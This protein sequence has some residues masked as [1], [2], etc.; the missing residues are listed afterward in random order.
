MRNIIFYRLK[1]G[2]CPVEDFFDSLTD[3]QFEKIA[4]VLDLI[5]QLDIVPH[6]YFK[7]LKGTDDIWKVRIQYG[8]NTF[9]L[10]GF[11]DTK[12]V[13]VLNHAFIKKT[14]KTPRNKIAISEQRKR[15]YLEN[16]GVI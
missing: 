15:E 8:N 3:K 9:R 6:A 2:K 5:E 11:F 13:F 7:K 16:K 12:N 1:S 14:Q 10:L 4:F